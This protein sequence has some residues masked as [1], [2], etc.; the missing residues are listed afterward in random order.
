[1]VREGRRSIRGVLRQLGP[2]FDPR[3]RRPLVLL[4]PASFAAF[5]GPLAV[6][7]ARA[8]FYAFPQSIRY[9]PGHAAVI[10]AI[11]VGVWRLCQV[12]PGD[13]WPAEVPPEAMRPPAARWMP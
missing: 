10:V 2:W 7:A 8:L 5:L 12:R 9:A 3:S 1:M 4:A 6:E 11:A 13:T